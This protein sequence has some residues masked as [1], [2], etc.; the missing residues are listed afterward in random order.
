[1]NESLNRRY[2]VHLIEDEG[3]ALVKAAGTEGRSVSNWLRRAIQAAL[4][5]DQQENYERRQ[6]QYRN[7]RHHPGAMR[8]HR[9]C[10]HRTQRPDIQEAGLEGPLRPVLVDD[11]RSVILAS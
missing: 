10:A 5:T 11:D 9:C 1:M 6:H 8:S 3:D 4:E 2:H 7:S